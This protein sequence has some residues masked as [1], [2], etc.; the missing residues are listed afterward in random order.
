MNLLAPAAAV[1]QVAH[2]ASVLKCSGEEDL[3]VV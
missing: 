1:L 2:K 3:T